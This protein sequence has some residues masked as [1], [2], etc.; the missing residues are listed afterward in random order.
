MSDKVCPICG[1]PIT[2]TDH[3]GVKLCRKRA[4][5]LEWLRRYRQEWRAK[6]KLRRGP[7]QREVKRLRLD[8]KE[9]S[10]R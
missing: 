4:C 10:G 5:R 9:G 2:W 8:W 3:T 6:A 1:D 7:K